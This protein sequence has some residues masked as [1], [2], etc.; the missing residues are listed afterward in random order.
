MMDGQHLFKVLPTQLE[1]ARSADNERSHL[2]EINA[3]VTKNQLSV[4]FT[5][6]PHYLDSGTITQ[7]ATDFIEI[8]RAMIQ[9]CLAPDAGGST[10]SDF[11]EANL[12]Q[13]A[14][15]DLLDEFSEVIE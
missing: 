2:L 9:H 5:Y 7:L 6:S 10:P 11:P 12:D 15:D 1:G 13:K 8:L 3:L 4:T 14:L